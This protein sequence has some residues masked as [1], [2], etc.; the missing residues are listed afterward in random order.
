MFLLAATGGAALG[1]LVLLGALKTLFDWLASGGGMSEK[2]PLFFRWLA[3]KKGKDIDWHWASWRAEEM[4][5]AAEN[6][7]L[8]APS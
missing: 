4:Q 6:E 7:E 5:L 1:F 8:V 3:K 2:P